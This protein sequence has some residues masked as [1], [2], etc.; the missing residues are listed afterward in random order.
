MSYTYEIT[1]AGKA[2]IAK[3]QTGEIINYS[4]VEV[5]KGTLSGAASE[6]SGL[7]EPVPTNVKI[8]QKEYIQGTGNTK[9]T[10]TY[11]NKDIAEGFYVKEIGL[12][13]NDPDVGEILFLYCYSS[14]ADYLPVASSTTVEQVVNLII[15]VDNAE[16]V[17]AQI[18]PETN[19]I[20]DNYSANSILKADLD[21]DPEALIVSENRIV[22]RKTGG[23]IDALTPD[24]VR[25]IQNTATNDAVFKS[26]VNVEGDLQ[27]NKYASGFLQ[28]DSLGNIT[29]Q[30]GFVMPW[31]TSAVPSGFLSCNG[32]SV[33]RTTYPELF[34]VIG[35][36]YGNVDADHFNLPDYRG[37]FLRGWDNGSGNDPDTGL[38]TDRGDDVSGD[39]VGTQQI[40]QFQ[41]FAMATRISSYGA[42]AAPLYWKGPYLAC[43]PA[44]S[45]SSIQGRAIKTEN[46]SSGTPRVGAETRPRNIAIHFII[47]T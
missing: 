47:K 34:A 2:L 11:T 31:P 15:A 16:N 13:A 3:A 22:G 7:I 26:K 10:L 9:I 30:A 36:E 27:L 32:A 29:S 41:D 38:R 42:G 45:E 24:D 21:N 43:N 40:D 20:R 25:D 5:G 19:V 23:V 4:K 46:G 35:T 6:L 18:T 12:F 14:D 1:S 8:Q 33:S 28:S 44:I 17:T 39:Y 37:E